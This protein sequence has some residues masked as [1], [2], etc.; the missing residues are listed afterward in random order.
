MARRDDL[1][2]GLDLGTTK[3]CA[4]VG[5]VTA[6]GIDIVGVGTTP[7]MG[8][9]GGVVVNIDQTVHAIRKAIEEAERMA[10]CEISAV[11][12]G[13]GGTHIASLNSHGVIAVKSRE[14]TA[15]DVDRVLEAAKAIAM[16]FDR[17]VLHVLPQQYIVDDQEGILDPLGM[18]GVRLEAKVHIVTGAVSALQNIVKCCEKAG[19]DVLDVVLESLASSESVLDPDERQLGVAMIDMGGGTTDLVVFREQ[20]IRYSSVIGLGGNHVTSDISVGLRTAIDEAEK[21]KKQYGCALT[22][23]VDPQEVIQ[24]GS[25]G[26]Q[27][28]RELARSILAEIIEARVEEML[29]VAELE[30]IRSGYLEN[31]HAGVVL[32]GGVSL[33]PGIRDLAERVFDLPVRVGVPYRFGGL[34]DVVK[35]PVYST[36]TGLLLYGQKHGPRFGGG[37]T[38]DA[39]PLGRFWRY[40]KRILKEF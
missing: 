35:N 5:E 19:L 14:V 24:V 16:P 26:G 15:M 28:P 21:I 3:V 34:G 10:G 12:V 40:L 18:S 25:V 2:V 31:L 17:R 23:R 29:K 6:E 22:D 27:K 38:I 7:S 36:A 20:A 11:Y 33:L 32:T 13:V 39:G 4:V 9:R 37:R 1:I 8:M 30:L